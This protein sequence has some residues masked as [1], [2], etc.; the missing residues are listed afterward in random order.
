MQVRRL[1][2]K[3]IMK[4]DDDNFVRIDA[5]LKEVNRLSRG[6]PLYI[7]NLNYFHKPLKV[8]KW[9]VTYEV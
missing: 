5:V 2:A 4:C 9:A 6:Q 7:G 8:G 1:A 3:Y